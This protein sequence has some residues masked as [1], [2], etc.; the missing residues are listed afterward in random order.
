MVDFEKCEIHGVL[1]FVASAVAVALTPL[2][3]QQPSK[4]AAT[5]AKSF[6]T[7]KTPWGDPDLRGVYTNND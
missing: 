5:K 1:T 4:P 7:P 3:A 2:S 6:A